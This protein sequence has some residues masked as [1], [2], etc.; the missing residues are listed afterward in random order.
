LRCSE[1]FE[2]W[3]F[4]LRFFAF[5]IARFASGVTFRWLP[6]RD[7]WN[8]TAIRTMSSTMM[9]QTKNRCTT[10]SSLDSIWLDRLYTG[11]SS[12]Q[13][14]CCGCGTNPE[15]AQDQ[16]R[17]PESDGGGCETAVAAISRYQSCVVA[18]FQTAPGMR[19]CERTCALTVL[20][21]FDIGV[22]ENIVDA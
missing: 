2:Q 15:E 14:S 20:G 18:R 16:R 7:R 11:T 22:F 21:Q 3:Q 9:A 4:H 19:L 13:L 10:T 5:S 12:D 1:I 17:R 8:A 6:D